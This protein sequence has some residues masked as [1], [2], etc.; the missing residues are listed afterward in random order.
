MNDQHFY[1][2]RHFKNLG[3]S[4]SDTEAS[5]SRVHTSRSQVV[6]DVG[7]NHGDTF[8]DLPLKQLDSIDGQDSLPKIYNISESPI[9]SKPQQP[10]SPPVGNHKASNVHIMAHRREG[11]VPVRNQHFNAI[12]RV[13]LLNAYPLLY[14]TLWLPGLANR[15]VEA[16]GHTSKVTQVMQLSTQFVGLA[17]AITFG[18]NEE[19]ARQVRKRS[20]RL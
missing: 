16:S 14:I 15:L 18:W 2:Q 7:P 11:E 1:L 13:L 17:N 10:R 4:L 5:A 19:V 8:S 3:A 6:I 9:R 20:S 12:E